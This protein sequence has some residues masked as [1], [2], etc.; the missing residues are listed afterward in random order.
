MFNLAMGWKIINLG[1][2][3]KIIHERTFQT[4]TIYVLKI[5]LLQATLKSYSR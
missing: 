4:P 5:I 1:V 3:I 2:Q